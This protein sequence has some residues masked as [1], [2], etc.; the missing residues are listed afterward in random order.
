V[1]RGRVVGVVSLTAALTF[2]A[3][4]PVQAT[5][6][7]APSIRVA[8]SV[9]AGGAVRVVGTSFG[10]CD[11]GGC[12]SSSPDWDAVTVEMR[13]VATAEIVASAQADIR[14]GEF[15]VQVPTPPDVPAGDYMVTAITQPDI[16]R[17]S[18]R[19]EVR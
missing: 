7:G 15:R 6:C 4:A 12:G 18:A 19:V 9:R 16:T 13:S 17:A 14:D 8:P 3:F 10:G 1:R 2:V 11:P 5:S